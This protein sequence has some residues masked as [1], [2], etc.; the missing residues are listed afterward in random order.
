MRARRRVL[1]LTFSLALAA[2]LPAALQAAETSLT[3]PGASDDLLAELRGSS[4][5]VSAETSGLDSA[6][7]L[8]AAALS[9]YKTLVQVL[10]DAGYFGP[11]V[12]I[13]VD[14]REAAN[15]SLV[16]PPRR[17]DRIEIRIATGP[18][19]RFGT[20]RVAPLPPGTE[21]PEA[22][23]T[24]QTAGTGTIR[25]AALAGRDAWR[26]DGHAKADIGAQRLTANHRLS[27][28]DADIQ[29]IPGPE[30]RF[31]QLKVSGQSRVRAASIQRIAALP[32]GEKFSPDEVRKAGARL[33]RTGTFS[34]V[35]LVEAETPN[36]DGTLDFTAQVADQPPRRISFG[37][38]IASNAGITLSAAW[39]HRNLFGNAERFRIEGE[40]R[41]IGG[42]EDID[43]GLAF[44]LD[45]PTRLGGDNSLFYVGS[46]ERIDRQHY[47]MNRAMLGVGVRRVS[48][49][50]LFGEASVEISTS[51]VTDAYGADRSFDLL[52]FPLRGQYDGRD[53]EQNPTGGY[54]VDLTITPFTGFGN[55]ASGI[56][57][58]ADGRA[59]RSLTASGSVVVAGRLQVGSVVGAAASETSPDLLFFSGGA[60]TVRGQGFESLGIPVGTGVAGGRSIVTASAELRTRITEAISLVGFYDYGAVDDGS[61]V[62]SAS[63]SHS[64]AGLG[65]RY[66]LGGFGPLRLDIALP[67]SGPTDDGLQFYI[68]IGQAF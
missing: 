1:P 38:E 61:F 16:N 17:I 35:S 32:S 19:F 55:S 2:L 68:G 36:A 65:L 64:G 37:A 60:G 3:A 4:S 30:L 42:D 31:G 14:G 57:M 5:V 13:R 54:F 46:L 41:N 22:F 48:S 66:D 25:A 21:L 11:E 27:Q 40:V 43:G 52:S 12:S 6:Q 34:S 51:D 47:T 44:R 49:D 67:V 29:I 53:S 23:A 28:V 26:F 10:Y 50:Q 8:L 45:N 39:L 15:I 7:E 9:D 59:Y 58:L 56:S 63:R 24:G 18:A 62:T 20:A 33:R